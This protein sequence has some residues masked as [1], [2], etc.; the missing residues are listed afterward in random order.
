MYKLSICGIAKNEQYGLREWVNYHRLVGVEH[1]YIYDNDSTVPV[2]ETLAQ[3][4]AAQ[5]VTCIEFPGPSKQMP[6][7]NDCLRRF[8]GDSQWIAMID[9]DEFL[10]PKKTDSVLDVLDNFGNYSSLQVNWVIFGSS[11][12]ITRPTGLVIENYTHSSPSSY[13]ENLHTKAIIQPSKIQCAGSNPHYFVPQHG[14]FAV[15][16]D[17]AGIPNAWSKTHNVETIQLNHYTI[18]S[19]EDFHAKMAKGRADAAHLPTA[20]LHHFESIDSVCIEQ[21]TSIFRFIEPTK[22]LLG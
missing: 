12:H 14:F 1:I 9:C 6:A 16:E 17:F 13:K 7:Y 10:V 2:R 5:Y 19:L 20:Q 18:K 21:D 15:G 22:V 4:I 8:G 3:E 11:G